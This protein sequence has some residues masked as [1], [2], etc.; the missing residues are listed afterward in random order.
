MAVLKSEPDIA[1]ENFQNLYVHLKN[2]RNN[3]DWIELMDK[4][5][6]HDVPYYETQLLGFV[7]SAK[8]AEEAQRM[9]VTEANVINGI[10]AIN[11][12]KSKLKDIEQNALKAQDTK[13]ITAKKPSNVVIN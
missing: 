7:T 2:L 4:Y 9:Q 10:K 11:W 3:P 12:L 1:Q 6:F 5:I 8:S 13:P